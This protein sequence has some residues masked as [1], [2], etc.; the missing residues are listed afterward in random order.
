VS[1]L[2]AFLMRSFV[3]KVGGNFGLISIRT[4]LE[5]LSPIF[6]VS[7][8]E[9]IISEVAILLFFYFKKVLGIKTII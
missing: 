7:I 9:L 1:A 5:L 6:V 4:L 3:V 2:R 8:F